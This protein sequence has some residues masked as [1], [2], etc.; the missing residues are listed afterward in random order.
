MWLGLGLN[1]L[2]IPVFKYSSKLALV[3]LLAMIGI[4]TVAQRQLYRDNFYWEFVNQFVYSLW[5]IF[6]LTLNAY[7]AIHCP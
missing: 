5:L 2:W 3:L 7:I 6:A 4:A 1:I